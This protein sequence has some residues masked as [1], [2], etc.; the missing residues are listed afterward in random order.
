MH[1]RPVFCERIVPVTQECTM[2]QFPLMKEPEKCSLF[3]GFRPI[4]GS[5][6]AF[7]QEVFAN[8]EFTESIVES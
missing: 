3:G 2:Q 7:K 1:G 5:D 6:D 8:E 4:K